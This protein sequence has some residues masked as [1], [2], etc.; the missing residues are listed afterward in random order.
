MS[1]FT[2][3]CMLLTAVMG[4]ELPLMFAKWLI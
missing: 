1:F 2:D 4:N 3:I